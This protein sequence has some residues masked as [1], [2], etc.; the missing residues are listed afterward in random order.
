M[1]NLDTFGLVQRNVCV[2]IAGLHGRRQVA[3]VHVGGQARDIVLGIELVDVLAQIGQ[4]HV[5]VL[6]VL[7]AELGQDAPHR[8][9]LGVV[10]LEL[11]QSGQHAIPATLGDAD[12]EHD[13]EAVQAGLLDHHPM[14]GKELGHDA[15]RNPGLGELAIQVHARRNH[16]RLDRIEHVEAGGHLAKTVPVDTGLGFGRFAFDDPAVGAANSFIDQLFRPPHL[17]PPVVAV[18]LIHLAHGTAEV[19]CFGDAFL[20]QCG[21]AR[22]LHHGG[23]HVATGDDAVL[24]AGAGMHQIG[25]IEE[26]LVELDGLRILHQHMAGLTDAGEQFVQGL[27]GIH[28]SVLGTRPVLAHGVVAAIKRMKRRVRQPGFVEMNVFHITVKQ[29]LHGFGVV[30]NAV[31]G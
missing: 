11:L 21:A 9:V 20:H 18:F 3:Q 8:L 29:A 10:V 13:E 5:L 4:T 7:L 2:G 25:L 31:V 15:G 23:G 12:G 16:R 6:R 22:R 17:E 24:W 19:Q 26:V 28:H 30:Q 27:R 1:V 14:L